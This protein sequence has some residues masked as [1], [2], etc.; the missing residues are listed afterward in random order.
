[1]R[2]GRGVLLA[3]SRHGAYKHRGG[4]GGG[5]KRRGEKE[6]CGVAYGYLRMDEEEEK[7]KEEEEEEVNQEKKIKGR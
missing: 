7:S 6:W 5:R 2:L 4:G 1:M 3:I